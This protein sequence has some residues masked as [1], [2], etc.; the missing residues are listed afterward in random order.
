M[1]S[2]STASKLIAPSR[3]ASS[4][5]AA[6][7]VS[8]KTSISRNAWMNSRLAAIAHAG[9]QE[10]PQ[11]LERFRKCPTLQGSRLVQGAGLLLEERQIVLRVEDELTTANR[12]AD[13]WRSRSRRR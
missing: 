13:A 11:M 5:A 10:P 7:S 1:T 4:A 9:F 2:C 8:G 6:T 3:I 12:R